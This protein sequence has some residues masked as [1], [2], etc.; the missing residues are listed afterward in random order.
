M[1]TSGHQA[2]KRTKQLIKITVKV[3]LSNTHTHT[4]VR[5]KKTSTIEFDLITLEKAFE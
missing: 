2:P 3:V 5:L 4:H 1:G